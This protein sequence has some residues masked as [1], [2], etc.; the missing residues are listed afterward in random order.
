[1]WNLTVQ[2][3]PSDYSS[4]TTITISWDN[5]YFYY[6]DYTSIVLYDVIN[7]IIVADM[8]ETESYTFNCPALALQNFQIICTTNTNQPP[9]IPSNPIPSNTA[10]DIDI[11]TS[12][13]WTGGDPDPEDIVTYDIYFGTT[14][15]PPKVISNQS[16]TIYNPGKL[17]NITV[18][19][20][21]IIAYDN[22]GATTSGPLWSFTTKK[23]K[24][25]SIEQTT[26]KKVVL[27]SNFRPQN[28]VNLIGV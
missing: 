17:I 2:W 12:L 6:N 23:S 10:T 19:Y 26:I 22:N 24:D 14:I 27:N 5:D 9:N 8:L 18:Y 4:P 16:T 11:E 28:L 20:W 7:N 3:I 1:V 15:S 13:S 25:L 21:R